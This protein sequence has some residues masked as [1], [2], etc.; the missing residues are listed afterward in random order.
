MCVLEVLEILEYSMMCPLLQMYELWFSCTTQNP[1][2]QKLN[3]N[4]L[5]RPAPLH[6]YSPFTVFF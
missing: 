3:I 2:I 1:S 6:P 5:P 4:T